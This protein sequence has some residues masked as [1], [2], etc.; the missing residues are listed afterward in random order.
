MNRIPTVLRWAFMLGLEFIAILAV[1]ASLNALN[2]GLAQSLAALAEG[3]VSILATV[4]L[5]TVGLC[6]V[7][8]ATRNR[9]W[10]RNAGD[11]AAF[12]AWVRSRRP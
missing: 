11:R 9:I 1:V 10:L 2:P 4:V 8:T 5:G 6:T 3:S 7:L 12:Q